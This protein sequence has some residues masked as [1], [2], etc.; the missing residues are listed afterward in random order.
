MAITDPTNIPDTDSPR[1]SWETPRPAAQTWRPASLPPLSSTPPIRADVPPVSSPQASY[2]PPAFDAS[3]LDASVKYD[4]AGNPIPGSGQPAT[5]PPAPFGYS[6]GNAPAEVWPPP[7]GGAG[8][9]F[10]AAQAYRNNSGEQ[11]H[12][13]PEIER[14]RWHWGAF[15][16]PTYWTR[17]HGLRQ[18]AFM[19]VGGLVLLRVL[20][21]AF[22][23]AN[24]VA[25]FAA[26]A[27]Y[28]VACF[29]VKVYFGLNGH[30][31][32][33]RNR[34]FPGG[35]EQYFEVQ[36]RWMWWG[37]GINIAGTVLLIALLIG[38]AVGGFN[39]MNSYGSF[40]RGS[41]GSYSTGY[42]SSSPN[43]FGNANGANQ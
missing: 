9:G 39:P 20:R 21:T 30:K 23:P 29:G 11:S 15:F 18:V 38:A 1:P 4:L 31:I 3:P 17:R 35:L 22:L 41:G 19:I 8:Q 26:C 33:W 14:L 16:F 2:A 43:N 27:L 12:L 36:K 34:H 24:S 13:P 42:H 6:A 25:F 5:P 40:N 10:G 37:F 7:V 32:G 28:V